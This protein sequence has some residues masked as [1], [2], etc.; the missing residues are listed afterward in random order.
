MYI[1]FKNLSWGLNWEIL[2]NG[3]GGAWQPLTYVSPAAFCSVSKRRRHNSTLMCIGIDAVRTTRMLR[4]RT[5][6][7]IITATGANSLPTNRFDLIELTFY[8]DLN[9]VNDVVCWTPSQSHEHRTQWENYV[10][11][12]IQAPKL[13]IYFNNLYLFFYKWAII[14]HT[15]FHLGK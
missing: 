1:S 4:M 9:E 6:Y 3:D 13:I 10:H 8:F 11:L 5:N 7:A 12:S 15:L 14:C 2:K